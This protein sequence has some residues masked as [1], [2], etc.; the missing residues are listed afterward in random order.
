MKGLKLSLVIMAAALLTIGLSGM[1]YAFHDG[2]VAYC[3]GCHTMHN[4]SGGQRMYRAANQASGPQ[5]VVGTTNQ[6]LLQ[7]TDQSSTCLMCH[8]GATLSSYH[9]LTWPLP[10]AGAAPANYTPGGDFAW[11]SKAYTW[12][13]GTSAGQIKGH[14]VVA[15]DFGLIADT[16]FTSG[17]PGGNYPQSALGCQSCHDPHGRYRI[18]DAS[19]TV[20]LPAIGSSVLP[21]DGSGSTGA[22][23]TTDAAVGVYRLLGGKGYYTKSA[24]AAYAFSNA[25]DPP[26]AVS[27]STYNRKET[28]SDTRVAYGSGMSQWCANCHGGFHN[29][30]YPTTLRHPSGQKLTAAVIAN[31]NAYVKSGDLTGLVGTAYTSLVPFEEGTTDRAALTTHAVFDG[32]QKGGADTNSVVM[33]LTCHRAHASAWDSSTRWNIKG[34]FLTEGGIYPTIADSPNE[35]QGRSDAETKAGMYDRPATVFA[36]Y[37]RSLCNKCH[38]KD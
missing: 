22:I 38:V 4:S 19:G 28:G 25:V 11:L 2:G 34:T 21:I 20:A 15:A 31:Y 24:G 17:A 32:S 37:Q 30:T 9:V 14:N 33:C 16:R 29:E 6:Y 1:A 12:P 13:R 5:G 10:A 7:G 8:S 27:P 3:E 18:V 35:A 23:P 26:I 36:T